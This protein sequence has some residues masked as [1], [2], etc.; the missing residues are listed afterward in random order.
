[1]KQQH[2]DVWKQQVC[3]VLLCMQTLMDA[4]ATLVIRAMTNSP[5]VLA[6][7]CLSLVVATRAAARRAHIGLRLASRA[8]AK[9]CHVVMLLDGSAHKC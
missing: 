5:M 6:L 7:T 9:V 3:L 4:P 1:M 2:F 8:A